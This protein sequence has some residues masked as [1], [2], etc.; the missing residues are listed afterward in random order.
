MGQSGGSYTLAY[1]INYITPTCITCPAYDYSITPTVYYQTHSESIVAG[2]CKVYELILAPGD[3][4]TFTFCDGGGTADYDTYLTLRDATCTTVA[5]NDDYCS[6]QSL[7]AYTTISGGTYYLEVNSCCTG[8]WG[9]N[10]TLAYKIDCTGNDECICATNV[11]T[12]PYNSG[13]AT[14]VGS[15]TETMPSSSCG[16]MSNIVWYSFTGTGNKVRIS[17]CD[18][19]TDFDTEIRVFTGD[20]ST[21]TEL[22]CND[23]MCVAY[24]GVASTVEFCS[25]TSEMYYIGVGCYSDNGCTGNYVL[26]IEEFILGTPDTINGSTIRCQGSGSETYTTFAANAM[27]YNWS[28]APPQAGSINAYTGEVTWDAGFSGTATISVFAVACSPTSPS[29]DLD[30]TVN[31]YPSAAGT[32]SGTPVVCQDATGIAYS[33]PVIADATSY[34][35]NFSGTGAT[36]NGSTENIT[37]DFSSSATSGNLTVAGQNTCGTGTVSADYYIDVQNCTFI[38]HSENSDIMIVPNPSTGH[39]QVFF[40]DSFYGKIS[41]RIFNELAQLVWQSDDVSVQESSYKLGN[42]IFT[43]TINSEGA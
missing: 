40:N 15:T 26:S 43:V 34:L 12:L 11:S 2:A 28:I 29:F 19:I 41:V 5:T 4:V 20:C 22:T 30:V 37:I 3:L 42:N 21:L 7:L 18:A 16:T 36:I 38:S 33:V 13:T 23:D 8:S 6:V 24:S 9:G 31:P 1:K 39:F 32:I 17:T 14:N 10:Y 25:F 35:W 27:F